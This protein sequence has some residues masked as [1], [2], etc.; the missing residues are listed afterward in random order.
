M[1]TDQYLNAVEWDVFLQRYQSIIEKEEDGD[2]F[3]DG[4]DF[5]MDSLEFDYDAGRC[6]S[7]EFGEFRSQLDADQRYFFHHF[8]FLVFPHYLCDNKLQD[9]R[10][11]DQT[12]TA[13]DAE[14]AEQHCEIVLCMLSPDSVS[15]G[16][17]LYQSLDLEQMRQIADATWSG[18]DFFKDPGHFVQFMKEMGEY[19][20]RTKA[21]SGGMIG[22]AWF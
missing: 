21:N 4:S 22:H 5:G 14:P 12:V 17:Q 6:L 15:L 2:D 20:Q 16:V 13:F 1:S 7:E 10:F 3:F 9:A 19:F 18:S 8:L 11:D